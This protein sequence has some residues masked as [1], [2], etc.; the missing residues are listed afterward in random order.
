MGSSDQPETT[1]MKNPDPATPGLPQSP[2]TPA[3]LPFSDEGS[4]YHIEM[5]SDQIAPDILI[6]GDPHR[7]EFIGSEFLRDIEVEQEHRGIVTVTGTAEFTG[8]RTTILSPTRT[9]VTTSG[10]ET[11]SLEIVVNELVA[12]NEINFKTRRRKMNYPRMNFIRVGTSGGLQPSTELG[13]PIVTSYAIGLDNTGLFYE[14]VCPDDECPRLERELSQL[15]K[16]EMREDSRFYGKI[17]PYVAQVDPLLVHAMLEA[18][19]SLGLTVKPGLTVS[20]PGFYAPQGRDISRLKPSV[21]NLDKIFADF[22]PGMDGLR[23]ENMEMEG[24]FLVHFL[25]G[26]GHRAGVICPAI[27]NRRMNTFTPNY[28]PFIEKS[29]QVALQALATLRKNDSRT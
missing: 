18:A 7:A 1:N 29:T 13:T 4:I 12:L 17:H 14:A 21:P 20:A 28:R 23:V 16:D 8:E 25:S 24:S 3:D 5:K 11:P 2:F 26:M 22:D 19:E 15:I 10:I 27:A 9:T 6:V